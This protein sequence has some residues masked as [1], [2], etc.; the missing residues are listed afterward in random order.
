MGT[1]RRVLKDFL[2]PLVPLVA[3]T[4][5]LCATGLDLAVERHFYLPGSGWIY[6]DLKIWRFLYSYGT[7]L[8]SAVAAGAIVLLCWSFFSRL[9][10]PYR[11]CALFFAL[12]ML[13][14]P[15]LLVS[16]VLK[17]NWGRPR[18]RQVEM[19]GGDRPYYPV[20][21]RGAPEAGRSFPSGHAATAFYLIAPYF[22]LRDS[23]RRRA[24]I[25]LAAGTAYGVL[26]GV[27]RM[28]QGGHFPSDV[29]WSGGCVY[30]V[31][32]LL[33]YL[34]GLHRGVLLSRGAPEGP[35][36]VPN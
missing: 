14:G 33:Y 26:V 25:A 29:L 32:M 30:L 23:S 10:Y 16:L 21:V 34:L 24:L 8:P 18:P 7:S 1:P 28:V 19:L 20:W 6:G 12:L 22:V 17:D 9:A 35:S 31:G 13:L 36:G 5:V 27:A 2:V 3:A 4:W 11:K 15:G